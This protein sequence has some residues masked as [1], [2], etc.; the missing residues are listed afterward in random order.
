ML[1]H[2][3]R[4]HP[5]LEHGVDFSK[6]PS[7]QLRDEEEGPDGAQKP[8]PTKDK[9]NFTSKVALIGIDLELVS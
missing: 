9:A 4:W 1:A 3:S 7:L 5:L 8:E 6:S 2:G